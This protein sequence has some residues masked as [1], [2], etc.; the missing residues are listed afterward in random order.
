MVTNC[1]Y[2]VGYQPCIPY[3][4]LSFDLT[5]VVKNIYFLEESARFL[6]KKVPRQIIGGGFD[7]HAEGGT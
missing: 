6:P 4:T 7:G 1:F 3:L 2:T 5:Q